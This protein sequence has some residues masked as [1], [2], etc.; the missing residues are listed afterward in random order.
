VAKN[1][2]IY[3]K[4]IDDRSIEGT[5]STQSKEQE[6]NK[7]FFIVKTELSRTREESSRR[8]IVQCRD[9]WLSLSGRDYPHISLDISADR[10]FLA[11]HGRA[12]MAYEL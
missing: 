12:R 4:Q 6:E 9:P 10:V 5:A 8:H 3:C 7:S 2:C 11:L 1:L